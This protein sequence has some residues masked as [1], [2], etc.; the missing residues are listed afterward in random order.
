MLA[1]RAAVTRS[2]ISKIEM[3]EREPKT[4]TLQK[5]AHALGVSIGSLLYESEPTPAPRAEIFGAYGRVPLVRP[6]HAG[7]EIIL[8]EYGNPEY[9]PGAMA[10]LGSLLAT[11]IQG[12]CLEPEIRPG[13]V[14]FFDTA[15]RDPQH[16]EI[17][18]VTS[19]EGE[20][21]LRRAIRTPDAA[22]WL[23]NRHNVMEQPNGLRLEGVVVQFLRRPGR[24]T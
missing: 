22:I 17:V 3:E 23:T 20:L 24:A 18:V 13:D 14:V 7:A 8:Q 2:A 16:G 4:A 1:Q 19:A 9:V 10:A 21:L 5:I 6:A 12:D 15:R 11:E